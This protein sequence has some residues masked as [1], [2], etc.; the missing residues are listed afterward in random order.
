MN[1]EFGMANQF[2][3]DLSVNT[4]RG[5]RNKIQQGR[6]PHKPP[7]YPDPFSFPI[8]RKL[9][10]ILLEKRCSLEKL[11][12]I[13]QEMGLKMDRGVKISRNNFYRLFRNPFYYG[14]FLWNDEV[15]PGKHEPMISK[16]DFDLA[17]RVVNSRSFPRTQTHVFAF[18]G[19]MRCGECG[20]FITAE[21]KVKHL[22]SGG[23][24]LHTYYRC[25]RRIKR[26]YSEPPIRCEDLESQILNILGTIT[27]PA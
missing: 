7:I 26:D 10:A 4:K 23:T 20:I 21:E 14:S 3:F 17:Q 25:T 5:Q 24:N 2:I 9:W 18:T 13:A 12:D 22:K 6:L 11:F 15:Y 8:M 19:L 1:L 16:T 27:I